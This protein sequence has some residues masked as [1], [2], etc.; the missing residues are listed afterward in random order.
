MQTGDT[1]VALAT[2]PGAGALG[3]VRLSGPG[4]VQALLP[5]WRGHDLQTVGSH[6]AHFGRLVDPSTGHVLDEVV[7]TLYRPPRSYTRELT[8]EVSCHGSPYILATLVR[9]LCA[10]GARPAEPGEFTLRAYLN[11][12]LDLAQAEAVGDLIASRSEAAQRLA[13]GQLRGGLSGRL[14]ELRQQLVDFAALLELELDFSEEDVEFA[15]RRQLLASIAHTRTELH[16]LLASFAGGNAVKAGIPTVIAGK[17][18]AGKSTLLNR[19]LNENRAIVSDIP[20]TTR[21]VIED[22]LLLG[23]YEFR[24]VDTAGLRAA[25][26]AIEA[27]G[28]ARSHARLQTASLVLYVFDAAAESVPAA[29]QAA[30][31]LAVPNA[32]RLILVANKTDLLS[33][34]PMPGETYPLVPVSA[35]QGVGLEA[36]QQQL[37]ACAQELAGGEE[38]ILTTQRHAV[39]LADADA[40]LQEVVAGLQA[41]SGQ[42]LVSLDLRRALQALGSVTGDV[43]PDE[44]LGSIFSRFCIGK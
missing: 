29:E 18:N 17:P 6:S 32:V 22:E 44:V 1:I 42:E 41:G 36:L 15:D 7:A 27:E 19:L 5:Y 4:A 38:T 12:A 9:W 8:V 10:A 34:P 20:G 33:R 39:A 13:M 40:A 23:G 16:R 14:R 30:Q 26:D 25:T 37:V 2:P 43:T 24:L 3:L 28:I 35:Q 31:A 21:D 11:G